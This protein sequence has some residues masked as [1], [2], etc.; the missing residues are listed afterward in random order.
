MAWTVDTCLLI[1]VAVDDPEFFVA[2]ARLLETHQTEGLVVCPISVVELAPVFAGQLPAVAEFLRRLNIL[3]PEAWTLV[4]TETAFASWHRYVADKRQG[5]ITKRPI[6]DVL[7]GAFASRH[8][9]LLTRNTTD[10][11]PLFPD[12][13]IVA[14]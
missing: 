14:P 11:R 8:Q 4:D 10:F 3:W 2:S 5:K 9:G 7:I 12:L 13:N 6:A 1:D